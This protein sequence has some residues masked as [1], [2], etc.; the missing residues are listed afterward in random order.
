MAIYRLTSNFFHKMPVKFERSIH[1]LQNLQ[2]MRK[3]EFGAIINQPGPSACVFFSFLGI[4]WVGGGKITPQ[5]RIG[6]MTVFECKM[7]YMRS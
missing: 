5:T 4:L 1:L 7:K 2:K 3:I 6:L